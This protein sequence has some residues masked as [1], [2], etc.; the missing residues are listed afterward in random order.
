MRMRVAETRPLQIVCA[1]RGSVLAASSASP[2]PR[3]H[4]GQGGQSRELILVTVPE[5][6]TARA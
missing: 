4:T 6:V 5:R 1:Q 3:A 2:S